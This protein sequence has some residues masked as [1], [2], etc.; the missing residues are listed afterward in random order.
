MLAKIMTY[1]S[2]IATFCIIFLMWW[3]VFVAIFT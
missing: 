1:I 3:L 2:G